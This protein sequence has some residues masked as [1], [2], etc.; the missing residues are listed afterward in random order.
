MSEALTLRTSR[1]AL[2]STRKK[3][4]KSPIFDEKIFVK[5]VLANLYNSVVIKDKEIFQVKTRTEHT[6]PPES[7]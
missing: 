5:W 4:G 1:A 6:L 3:W 2:L 7:R